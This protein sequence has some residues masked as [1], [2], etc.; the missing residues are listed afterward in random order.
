MER[1]LTEPPHYVETFLQKPGQG[2][3]SLRRKKMQ[4]RNYAGLF[5]ALVIGFGAIEAHAAEVRSVTI[6]RPRLG[7]SSASAASSR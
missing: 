4:R 5:A 7:R 2:P 3:G 6:S 1:I